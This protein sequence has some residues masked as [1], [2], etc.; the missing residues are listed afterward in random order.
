MAFSSPPSKRPVG[1]WRRLTATLHP[2]STRLQ[3]DPDYR[4]QSYEEVALAA[5]WG[6]RLDVNRA[7]P[8]DWLRLP[9]LS[10]HQ[11]RTLSQLTSAGVQ[12]HCIED[13]AAALSLPQESLVP[14]APVLAFYY[15]AP[16]SE[17]ARQTLDPNVACVQELA[18]LPTVSPR[19]A[20]AIVRE[21]QR[22]CVRNA[23]EC[24]ARRQLGPELMRRRMHQ[25][26]L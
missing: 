21:R 10:I 23:A 6:F 8:D 18:A 7:T 2:L 20:Q 3:Q 22:G 4:F 19:L 15:Y 24:Q 5:S 1:R 26:R 25:P 14:I 13:I 9:G 17:A 11:A 12:F 16:S